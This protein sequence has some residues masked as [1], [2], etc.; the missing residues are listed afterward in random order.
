MT[1]SD[2]DETGVVAIGAGTV[3]RHDGPDPKE[4]PA[5]HNLL[6][7]SSEI[8]SG[9]EPL[10]NEA[11]ES[12]VRLGVK[13]VVSVD[14]AAPDVETARK[15]GLRYVHIPIG[16]DGIEEEAGRL[17]A[18]LVRDANGPFYIHCHHGRHRGPAAA[19]V[20]CV[21]SGE[22][23]GQGAIE[24]L[25]RAGTSR[26]YAGLWRDVKNYRAPG[27]NEELPELREVAEVGSFT[28]A[29]ARIDRAYDHLKRCR[30]AEWS[31]PE[32]H[33]DLV[34]AQE[35]LLLKEGLRESAR[36][37]A[38]DF[39]EEFKSWLADAEGV[40]Q[41]LE[42]SLKANDPVQKISRQFQRLEESCRTCHSRYRD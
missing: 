20:A 26:D 2:P 24:I 8:Y 25:V 6:T 23:N 33:P 22:M 29:M 5:L 4:Y 15:H 18:R 1:A 32:D 36:N 34:P 37:L 14:G 40:A 42:E 31:T 9:G 17:L 21:A 30:D 16:Y 7:V 3:S 10:G 38:S 41:G 39:G 13:T 27:A 12:L 19:A 11:F 35:A 28:S